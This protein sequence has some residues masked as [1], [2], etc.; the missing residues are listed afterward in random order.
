M[1]TSNYMKTEYQ[2]T[3]ENEDNIEVDKKKDPFYNW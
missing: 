1:D 2:N 3:E